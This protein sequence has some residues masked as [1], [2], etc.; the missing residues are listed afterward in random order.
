MPA[1]IEKI[2]VG[3]L[4][5]ELTP[6]VIAKAEQMLKEFVVC[7]LTSLAAMSPTDLDDQVIARVATLLGVTCPAAPAAA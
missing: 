7:E 5:K 1:W 4:M 3:I 6:E 2:L